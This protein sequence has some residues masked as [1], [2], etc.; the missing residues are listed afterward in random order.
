[1]SEEKKNKPIFKIKAG[2]ISASV[3]SNHFKG[4]NGKPD[5]DMES[6]SIQKSYTKDEGK[7]WEN[8]SISI[9]KADIIKLKIVLDKI[10]EQQFLKEKEIIEE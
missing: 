6:I 2:N 4:S 1:M 9:R 5:F 7:T 8:Q 10:A 3:F